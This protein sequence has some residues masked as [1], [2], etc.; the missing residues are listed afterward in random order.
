MVKVFYGKLDWGILKS[1]QLEDNVL[2]SCYLKCVL[3]QWNGVR[4]N[5]LRWKL[6]KHLLVFKRSLSV[7][8]NATE[9]FSNSFGAV[10]ISAFERLAW[11][12]R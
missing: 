5:A 4:K 10:E 7:M 8:K 3:S 12:R 9:I 2:F 6:F 1:L 11:W